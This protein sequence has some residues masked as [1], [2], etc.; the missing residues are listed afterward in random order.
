VGLEYTTRYFG[1][2]YKLSENVSTLL[3]TYV[4]RT[5]LLVAVSLFFA[6]AIAIPIGL[7]QGYRRKRADD[8]ALSG[9]ML[10]MYSMPTFLLGVIL[11]FVF[12][13]WLP[14]LPSTATNFGGSLSID[15]TDL[16]LPIITLCFANVSYFSRYMRSSVFDN[17][18]ED[19]VRTAKS[20]GASNSTVLLQHVLRNSLNSTRTLMGLSLPYTISG[21]LIVEALF[22]YPGAGLLFWN[23]AQARDFPVLLV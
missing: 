23:S 7:W 22:K 6:I 12:S 3:A 19:Y 14:V 5:F 2:S 11:I 21:S 18:L 10:I 13:I 8:H 17:L 20:K 4:P 1:Y 16:A 15:V 9:T